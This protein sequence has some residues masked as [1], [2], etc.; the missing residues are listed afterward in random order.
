M[1]GD[2]ATPCD[3]TVTC[4][5]YMVYEGVSKIFRTGAAIYI[6]VVLS[7]TPVDSATTM[8]CESVCQVSRSWVDVRSFHTRLV[9][10][11]MISTASVRNILDTSSY[12]G[13]VE[14]SHWAT[15][16]HVLTPSLLACLCPHPSFGHVSSDYILITFDT[17]IRF[18]LVDAYQWSLGVRG[19]RQWS[20]D[21]EIC[22]GPVIHTINGTSFCDLLVMLSSGLYFKFSVSTKMQ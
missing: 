11:F 1:K 12:Y 13:Y 8:S 3:F 4:S 20:R 15:L 9:A 17:D 16:P 7:R 5:D 22:V 19:R 6:A 10:R 21:W 2:A 18:G 14:K